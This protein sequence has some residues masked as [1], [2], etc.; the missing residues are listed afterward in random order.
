LGDKATPFDGTEFE[1][2]LR[3]T[4]V[5]NDIAFVAMDLMAHGASKVSRSSQEYP[6]RMVALG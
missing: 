2:E 3:Y 5:L 6:H 4:D 1:P